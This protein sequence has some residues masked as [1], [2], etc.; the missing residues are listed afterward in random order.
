MSRKKHPDKEIEAVIQ[1]A[2]SRGW[3]YKKAGASAH[4]WGRL[5][6]PLHTRDGCMMSIW[7]TPRNSVNHADQI[8][9]KTDQCPH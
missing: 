8:R 5:I 6:C 3:H 2:E 1:Y 4:A 7:S 9:K